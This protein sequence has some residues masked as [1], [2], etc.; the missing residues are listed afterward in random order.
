[1]N[2][3]ARFGAVRGTLRAKV[4]GGAAVLAASATGSRVGELNVR[5]AF[6]YLSADGIPL[7]ASD[8]GGTRARRI[9]LFAKTGRVLLKRLGAEKTV[10]VEAEETDYGRRTAAVP[11]GGVT[12]F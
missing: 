7:D 4:F 3:L 8:T 6:D 10:A 11:D 2:G 5:F 9:Y 1:M 12:L